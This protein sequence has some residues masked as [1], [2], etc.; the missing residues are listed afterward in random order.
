MLYTALLRPLLF[1]LSRRDP[2]TVHESTSPDAQ[3]IEATPPLRALLRLRYSFR[4]QSLGRTVAGI[5]FPT[6]SG[7]RR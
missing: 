3:I 5:A 7:W 1:A 4:H 6:R 2:E